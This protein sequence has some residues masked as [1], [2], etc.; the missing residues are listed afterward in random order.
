MNRFANILRGLLAGCL[1]GLVY[2]GAVAQTVKLTVVPMSPGKLAAIGKSSYTA[3]TGLKVIGKGARAYLFADT[4]GSGTTVVTSFT[5]TFAAKPTGSNASFDSAGNNP[6]QSFT[7]DSAGQYIVNVSVNGGTSTDQ[8]TFF[9]STFLGNPNTSGLYCGECHAANY[10]DWQGTGHAK[11]YT[12]GIMGELEVNAYGQGSYS[13]SCWKCHTTGYDLSANDGNFGYMAHSLG[14]DTTAFK[15]KTKS[16]SSYLIFNGDSSIYKNMAANYSSLLPLASIGCESCH[17]PGKDHNGDISKIGLSLDAGLCQSCHD[18]PP[19]H[20]SGTY[21]SLSDH[22]TMPLA[23]KVATSTSC[24]PCHSGSAFEKWVVAGKPASASTW[25]SSDASYPITCAVC[26]DP[27]SAANP[28]QLRTVSVDTLRNGYVV[29]AGIGGLGQLCMNCHRSRYN[30]ATKVTTKAPYYGFADHYGP[31]GNPQADMFFGQNAYQYGDSSLTG[32][33][34]HAGVPDACVTCHMHG[35]GQH[36]LS[37]S[38]TVGTG[39]MHDHT[40]ACQ[41]C[42]GSGIQ[43]F[44]DVKASYDYDRNGKIEGVQTEVAGLLA[45]LKARL[46]IDSLTGEPTLA[47]KDSLKV[48]NRPDL[49]QGIYTYSFVTND[50][51]MGV[52]NA[53][54]AVAL[55]QKALG[56]YP[57]GVEVVSQKTP[58]SYEISQNYPNPFN[59]STNI[60][61]SV[62]RSATIQ[63][64]VYNILG[65]L[66]KTLV[67]GDIVSG[68]Y[69][70]TW[71]GTNNHGATVSSGIYFYRLV[72]QSNGAPNYIVTKKMLMMK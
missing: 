63:L 58:T 28:N 11:I 40:E 50:G 41:T 12:Q 65:E 45:L 55:L 49:V 37:M 59:P 67:S 2:S 61:F 4:T 6:R 10:S 30:V 8:D 18:A 13:A 1:L 9:V 14:W 64:N 39:V 7:A 35:S 48:K 42:H 46:P 57:T 27:H 5:W 60:E 25:S 34:T 56:F 70:V 31:H 33:M 53:K 22:A 15:G 29:P 51:S 52:H 23:G 72:A 47:I 24:F 17:G 54:Y 44:D 3:T 19:H 38:D 69:K 32:L 66:V 16:G 43:S 21:W 62:P 26:H 71:N 68:H 36:Q 20:V